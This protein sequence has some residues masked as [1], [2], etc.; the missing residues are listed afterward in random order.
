MARMRMP[1][2]PFK[3]QKRFWTVVEDLSP[4]ADAV[5]SHFSAKGFQVAS[6]RTATGAWDIDVTKSGTFRTVSGLNTSLKIRIESL[7]DSV[8]ARAGI[9]IL[10]A[11]VLPTAIALLVFWP[12]VV[13]QV[14][15]VVRAA[16]L[17][18]EALMVIETALSTGSSGAVPG[19]YGTPAAPTATFCP[20]C[21]AARAG[22][23]KFC[24]SCG[25]AME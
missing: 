18:D 19:A 6:V 14:W 9:G 21:G 12:V 4:V 1:T 23:A 15:G 25:G 17:D 2:D 10:G 5:Q 13:T 11:Q 16:K 22:T 3:T 7:D 20:S 8:M 24:V